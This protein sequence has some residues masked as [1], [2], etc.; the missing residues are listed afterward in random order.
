MSSKRQT[1]LVRGLPMMIKLKYLNLEKYG[2][3]SRYSWITFPGNRNFYGRKLRCHLRFTDSILVE[4]LD[5]HNKYRPVLNRAINILI[6]A[7]YKYP[8]HE[9]YRHDPI[10]ILNFKCWNIRKIKKNYLMQ[11][12]KVYFWT[13][14]VT[15]S[16]FFGKIF[17]K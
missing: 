10:N 7:T 14:S 3:Y 17:N 11:N 13:K 15:Q 12:F 4:V 5:W 8:V 1:N 2:V 16:T 6:W 9:S